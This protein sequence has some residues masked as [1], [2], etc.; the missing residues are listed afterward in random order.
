[1]RCRKC[2][3]DIGGLGDEFTIYEGKKW[4]ECFFVKDIIEKANKNTLKKIDKIMAKST[5]VDLKSG[6]DALLDIHLFIQEGLMK[7]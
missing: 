2:G 3:E 6:E 4:C 1:M 7:K 5:Q